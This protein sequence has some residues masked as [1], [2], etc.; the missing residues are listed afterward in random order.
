MDGTRLQGSRTQ[1]QIAE[2]TRQ[3]LL[4][5]SRALQGLQ[6][7]VEKESLRV[8]QSGALSQRPHPQALGSPLTHGAITTDFSEAQLELITAV[9]PSPEACLQELTDIHRF[10]YANL[11]DELLWPSSMPCILGED[12]SIPVGQ[13]GPS[14]IGQAKTVYRLGLGLR[15]GRL[16]QTISGIHYNFSIPD[17]LWMAL[18]IT[19]QDQRTDRYFGLIRNFR[20]WSWLLIYLF[21]A[22]PAVCR[23]FTRHLD[24]QLESFDDGSQY[25]P[26]ATSLR[27]G[28]LGYQSNAQS[29]LEISYNSLAQYTDSMV[30]ALTQ[31]Y[32]DYVAKGTKQHDVYQQ[33]NTTVLQIENEFYGTIRP[34]RSTE[35]NERPVAALRKHGVEYVEV[36]CLDLNPFS[37]VGLDETQ[38]RFLD[39]F[40]IVCLLATSEP[41]SPEEFSQLAQNQLAVVER[42]R[43]PDLLL[44]T[45]NEQPLSLKRW[46]S[47][48]LDECA[49]IAHLLD[50]SEETNLYSLA[51]QQQREKLVDA[52]LTPSAQVLASMRHNR[53]PFFRFSMN[54]ALAHQQFFETLPLTAAEQSRFELSVAQSF[55]DQSAI[56]AA[57]QL[58]FDGFL[59]QYLALT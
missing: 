53:M 31:E 7:G 40:L 13:Y 51:T 43:D 6:R 23:S 10:V 45:D 56:E 29:T 12:D 48:L 17:N 50:L 42:G 54:H 26:Y 1:P 8:T 25:L 20:R 36:R 55:Q 5:A 9:H 32:P 58:D 19:T 46:G 34:K 35:S 52:E 33:L 59:K 57:D 3:T 44:H 41:D 49:S 37:P 27:M 4:G 11:Q 14:N 24:H 15:Y 21:G 28:P 16:M 38:M 2:S 39:T 18:G 22:S 30:T 47:V